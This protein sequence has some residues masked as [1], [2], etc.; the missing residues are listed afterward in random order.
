MAKSFIEG[1]KEKARLHRKTIVLP[2]G[3]DWRILQAAS[4]AVREGIARPIVL[5]DPDA[6]GRLAAEHIQTAHGRGTIRGH[7]F[8]AYELAQRLV[9]ADA[10]GA[11]T[12][13]LNWPVN[14]PS[15]GCSFDD[16]VGQIALAALQA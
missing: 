5:G 11:V 3:N 10:F 9:G 6:V 7:A 4:I 15:R 8:I 1:V 12:Q 13:G 14:E 2:G 16:A